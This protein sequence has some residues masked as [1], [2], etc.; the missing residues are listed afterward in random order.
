MGMKFKYKIAI[1][2]VLLLLVSKL[3]AQEGT[4]P[5]TANLNLIYPELDHQKISKP[6]Q[7]AAKTNTG[8]INLP[9]FDD[10]YYASYSNYP[11]QN[12]WSDSSLYINTGMPRAPMTIGVATFDGLN[13]KGYPYTPTYSFTAT[14][15]F[16]ADTLT[17]KSINLY[18]FNTQT[19]QPTDSVALI[20]YYQ[21]GG[22]GDSPEAQ[23][24]LL[25][26]FYKPAQAVWSSRQWAL[27]GNT[28]LNNNDS[29]FKRA[30]IW[31]TDTAFFHD[32][33]K[34]RFRNKAATN[35]NYDNWHIDY[36]Y[37]DKNRSILADTAWNDLSFGYV[38]TPFLKGYSN[39]PWHQFTDADMATK[40]SNYIRYNGTTTVNTTYQYQIYNGSNVL[41]NSNGYGAANLAP[42]K[43]GGWQHNTVHSNP[44]LSYTFAPMTD[45]MDFTIKHYMLNLAGDV[46][47]GNDTVIQKHQFRNYF[48]YDDGSCETGYYILG[49]G[50]RMAQKYKLNVAD[51]LWGV[52]IYF[53]PVGNVT[54][55]QNNYKMK[56]NVYTDNGSG[57]GTKFYTSDSIYPVYSTK[58]HN[59]FREYKFSTP[60]TLNS[61]SYYIGIQQFI[62][63][64][65]TIGFDR[66]YDSSPNL[67][68]D[69]GNGWTQSSVKGSLMMR[70]V[71]GRKLTSPVG[72]KE[73]M[74]RAEN[75]R[76][77]PNPANDQI[78]IQI[79]ENATDFTCNLYSINGSLIAS[80][81][82]NESNA[83]IDTQKLSNGVYLLVISSP[84]KGK[85]HQKVIVQH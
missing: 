29:L 55:Q 31:I 8:S 78:Q 62:A 65:I 35:G 30:F 76:V 46:N 13:K 59:S 1:N 72:I 40:Y 75:V 53:D 34:F 47:I 23:D 70:P 16:P 33:F 18:T 54:F 64:G 24:S 27:R 73:N 79:A 20:F 3:V 51:T 39:M 21:L 41:I 17:S 48:S 49:T 38:P 84:T 26:D 58:G 36:V 71:F 6:K 37:L 14:Q 68:Y 61:G 74:I 83:S 7:L 10:F 81:Q 22:N 32:G 25:V 5:M 43:T 57:P 44:N 19:L 2:L 15:A 63:S 77:Y 12:L 66:N 52:R 50:G 82:M 69:S 11:D 4:R 9:F 60:L 56:I 67:Y 45:S 80:Q 42:F 85:Y 28:I